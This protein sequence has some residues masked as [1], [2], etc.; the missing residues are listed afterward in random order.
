MGEVVTRTGV[1]DLTRKY[2][3]DA[4]V[5]T[6]YTCVVVCVQVCDILY[7]VSRVD[8]LAR[9]MRHVLSRKPGHVWVGDVRVVV[10]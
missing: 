7:N 6:G 1:G 10:Q 4:H 9:A 5:L 8:V 3:H 2:R